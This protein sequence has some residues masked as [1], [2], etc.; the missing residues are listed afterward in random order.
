MY[1]LIYA[2]FS[3]LNDKA[4]AQQSYGPMPAVNGDC[5]NYPDGWSERDL[6]SVIRDHSF[7]SPANLS[8][9]DLEDAT[10]IGIE[11][12]YANFR[13]AN[14]LGATFRDADLRGATL[15]DA[16]LSFASFSGANL[17]GATLSRA[18]LHSATLTGADLS[19]AILTDT[20]LAG[21][22]V[23]DALW[24]PRGR[25][26]NDTLFDLVGV[27]TL[28]FCGRQN[29][30][31]SSLRDQFR[32][33]GLRHHEREATF[34]LERTRTR[35]LMRDFNDNYTE[36]CDDILY[37]IPPSTLGDMIE[38]WFRYAFLELPIG[39][40]F[41]TGRP[42]QVIGS[43]ML[44][45][46]L[47]YSAAV[48]VP[49]KSGGMLRIWP[50][51]RL[52]RDSNGKWSVATDSPVEPL[53][54]IGW[55]AFAFGAYFSLLSAFHFGWRDFNVSNWLTKVQPSEFALR[56]HGWVRVVSGVQALLS[57]YFLAMWALFY[58]GRP[59][60]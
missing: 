59:L 31:L 12:P 60:Q 47:M 27:D 2:S 16:I 37:P 29:G 49:T 50:A 1:L 23:T 15:S 10:F 35:Y 36:S 51:D 18:N 44:L 46:M 22:N 43:L 11:L 25:P 21:A 17:S 58:F 33:A 13:R 39:Y 52:K 9:L 7:D 32:E 20:N 5:S 4:A 8:C 56:A 28:W 3:L 55:K 34:A 54:F 26:S 53:H 24:Q 38:G 6:V 48:A 40:G 41:Y 42:W 45:G 14:L 30:P 19:F 57:L